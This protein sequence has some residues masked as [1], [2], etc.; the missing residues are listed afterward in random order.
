MIGGEVDE[1]LKVLHFVL[2][3]RV[4]KDLIE[5]PDTD[6]DVGSGEYT[7]SVR[8]FLTHGNSAAYYR[9][10]QRHTV[11]SGGEL[12]IHSVR[13]TSSVTSPG[14]T[15]G[16]CTIFIN[17]RL[18]ECAPLRKAIGDIYSRYDLYLSY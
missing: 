5:L 12:I 11:Y 14:S 1:Q 6:I 15:G 17:G 8:G 9:G 4:A 18:V 7:A 3:D 13:P 10:S 2:G 16:W